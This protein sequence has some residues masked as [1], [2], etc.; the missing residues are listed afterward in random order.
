MRVRLVDPDGTPLRPSVVAVSLFG[1]L[2]L[3]CWAGAYAQGGGNLAGAGNHGP[4]AIRFSADSRIAYVVEADTGTVAMLDTATGRVLR[5]SPTGGEEPY[6]LALA[7][8][9]ARL[10]VTNRLSGSVAILDAATGQRVALLPL[11][12]MPADVVV[13]PDERAAYVAVSQLDQVAIIDLDK[14][15][16]VARMAVGRRP[17]SLALSADGKRLYCGNFQAGDVS[18]MDTAQRKETARIRMPGVN[19]AGLVLGPGEERLWASFQRPLNDRRTEN[20][21]DIWHN[22]V[23]AARLAGP[24]SP[25]SDEFGLDDGPTGA[26]DPAALALSREGERAWVALAGVDQ[27]ATFSVG[28]REGSPFSPASVTRIDVGANPREIALTPDGSQLWVANHLGNSVSIIDTARRTVSRTIDLGDTPPK[29]LALPGR[30]I[31]NHAGLTRG[32]RFTCNSCHPEGGSDGLSWNFAHTDDGLGKR[33]SKHLRGPV[34]FTGPFRWVGKEEDI[35]I[36]FQDEITGLLHGAQQPHGPLH[37]LWDMADNLPLPPNP[38]RA[39]GGSFTPAARR[40]KR[41]FDTKA[42]CGSCHDGEYQGGSGKKAFIG[43][44]AG[45]KKLDIPHLQGTY[46]SAPY[47]HDGRA[48]TLDAVF[49][50]HNGQKRHGKAHLLS[51][52]ELRDL[53]QY[54]R[55]L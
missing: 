30:R 52:A 5:R 28:A 7:P 44:T 9:R 15:A 47:L 45:G 8:Q 36:F 3:V 10:I 1:L 13:T 51:A 50:Q 16:I 17:R 27:V 39:P 6:G 40:G 11:R 35:E 46:D 53:I 12:G 21:A 14:R 22:F 38:H 37:S 4:L 31:F 48:P 29:N 33:N 49:R 20:P 34:L 42:G 54:L 18:V 23:G 55:E 41:L 32:Q 26:A 43:T 2:A 19:L 25:R 24:Q